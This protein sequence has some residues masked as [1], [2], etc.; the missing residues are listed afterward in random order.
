MAA[1]PILSILRTSCR[2]IKSN[3]KYSADLICSQTAIVAIGRARSPEAAANEHEA[4]STLEWAISRAA[5]A[6]LLKE[7][8]TRRR[9]LIAKAHSGYN[10]ALKLIVLSRTTNIKVQRTLAHLE[11]FLLEWERVRSRVPIHQPHEHQP[12][13]PRDSHQV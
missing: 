1:R 6:I 12:G 9:V 2:S 5:D 7:D 11:R 3:K 8:I 10:R 4:L 13:N